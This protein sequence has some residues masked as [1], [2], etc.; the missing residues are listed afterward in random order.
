MRLAGEF[1]HYHE[2]LFLSVS[3]PVQLVAQFLKLHLKLEIVTVQ[4]MNTSLVLVLQVNIQ[5]ICLSWVLILPM[6][7]FHLIEQGRL[8]FCHKQVALTTEFT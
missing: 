6:R 3:R 4:V 7:T 1:L 2:G 8:V 5:R